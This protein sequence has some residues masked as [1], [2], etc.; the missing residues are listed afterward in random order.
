MKDM[1]SGFTF[2]KI[3]GV[4][5]AIHFQREKTQPKLVRCLSGR[6]F[7]VVVDLR[8]DSKT[9]GKWQGFYLSG[10]NNEELLIPGQCGHGYLVLEPS[11]VLYKCSE[12]F[13]GEFDDGIIWNESE[14]NIQ[15]PIEGIGDIILSGRDKNLQ[16]F[17]EFKER[18]GGL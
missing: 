3:K 9:F 13:Y 18:Y 12:K 11:I 10:E 6:I 14:L 7:D 16:T 1:A 2:E 8:R 5:R 17:S 15:W 4:I